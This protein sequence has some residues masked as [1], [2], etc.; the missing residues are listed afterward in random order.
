LLAGICG[1]VGEFGAEAALRRH[2]AG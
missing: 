1:G 2:L